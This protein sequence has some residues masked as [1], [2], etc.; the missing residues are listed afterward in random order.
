MLITTKENYV[1]IKSANTRC[2]KEIKICKDKY[3]DE[4][5]RLQQLIIMSI[6]N[7]KKM[8]VLTSYYKIDI[9]ESIFRLETC[10]VE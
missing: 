3:S 10:N 1:L 9:C 6:Q 8:E 7:P 5:S 4:R 2:D